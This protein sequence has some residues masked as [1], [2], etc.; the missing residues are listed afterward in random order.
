MHKDLPIQYVSI[1]G[2]VRGTYRGELFHDVPDHD[3]TSVKMGRVFLDTENGPLAI[4]GG[5]SLLTQLKA[6]QLEDGDQIIIHR[7]DE[8]SFHVLK[9]VPSP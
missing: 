1:G 8:E 6:L 4:G 9:E 3:E 7:V 2:S 5:D